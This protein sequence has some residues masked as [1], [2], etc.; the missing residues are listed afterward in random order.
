LSKKDTIESIDD[1]KRLVVSVESTLLPKC[2]EREGSLEREQ[3][4]QS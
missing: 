1:H 4:R 3:L 2:H